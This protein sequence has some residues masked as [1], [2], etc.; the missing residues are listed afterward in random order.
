MHVV[1]A[2]QVWGQVLLLEMFAC[3]V[4]IAS[5]IDQERHQFGRQLLAPQ[6]VGPQGVEQGGLH[7][8]EH[9]P[10]L[11]GSKTWIVSL[12]EPLL[13]G[14]RIESRGMPWSARAFCETRT[15]GLDPTPDSMDANA[16]VFRQLRRGQSSVLV[17]SLPCPRAWAPTFRITLRYTSNRLF[18]ASFGPRAPRVITWTPSARIFNEI[19]TPLST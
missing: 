10:L 7:N 18:F 6:L 8:L 5:L 17:H 9:V 4:E 1:I 13:H 14:N 16:E 12:I 2:Q 15:L 19:N 11:L 3:E